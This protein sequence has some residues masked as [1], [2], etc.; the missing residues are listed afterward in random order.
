MTVDIVWDGGATWAA[1]RVRYGQCLGTRPSGVGTAQRSHRL[2]D[3]LDHA[4]WQRG[5]RRGQL[6]AA[7]VLCICLC[8]PLAREHH[9]D[10]HLEPLHTSAS[11]SIAAY[12][13]ALRLCDRVF[14]CNRVYRRCDSGEGSTR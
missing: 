6:C 10:E 7:A 12:V 14:T 8:M 5:E 2:C 11:V 13:T 4:R 3:H 1:G 9:G